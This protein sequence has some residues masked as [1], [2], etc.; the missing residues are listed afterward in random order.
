M[1]RLTIE[2]CGFG[3]NSTLSRISSPDVSLDPFWGLER[4]W[5]ENR[6]NVSCVPTGVYTLVPWTSPKFGEIYTIVGGSVSPYPGTAARSFCHFHAANRWGELLGC[7]AP[8]ERWGQTA[9]ERDF[10]VSSSRSALKR[11]VKWAD[12]EPV[13]ANFLHE[14]SQKRQ[15]FQ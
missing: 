7:L 15:G 10:K 8:G 12:G 13:F 3:E 4:S 6:S 9:A 1:K 11:F 5:K 14:P 2:R